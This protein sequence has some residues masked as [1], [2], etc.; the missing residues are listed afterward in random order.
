MATI[1][2]NAGDTSTGK[3]LTGDIMQVYGTAENTKV[4][5]DGQLNVFN[6]GSANSTTVSAGGAFT[7]SN[8][9]VATI[10]TVKQDGA[11]TVVLG[12]NATS[13]TVSTG[14]AA[15]VAG[16]ATST[17]LSGG[18][19]YVS[20]GGTATIATVK[21]G[22]TMHVSNGGQAISATV[23][24]GGLTIF[25]GG[26]ATSTTVKSNGEMT[27]AQNATATGTTA[28]NGGTVKV[29]GQVTGTVLSGS[30]DAYLQV[31]DGGQAMTTTVGYHGLMYV[32][33][34]GQATGTTVN[35]N[36]SMHVS[37]GGQ[38][39]G[40]TV[41]HNGFL[42]VSNGGSVNDTVVSG[43]LYVS[44]GGS[45][46]GVDVKTGGCLY[47][48]TGGKATGKL[49]F[50]DG[51]TVEAQAGAI[52]DFDISGLSPENAVLVNN[53]SL[54][55][56]SPSF[57]LTVDDSQA[58]GNYK[59]AA[60]LASFDKTITVVNTSGT[61]L[62][63]ITVA[64]GKKT[65]DGRDYT[66]TLTDGSLSVTLGAAALI[67]DL[68]GDLTSE[69]HLTAGKYASS[70]NVKNGGDLLIKNGGIATQTTV[71]ANGG[72]NVSS[73]G[74]ADKTTVN[75]NGYMT[76]SSGGVATN[77]TLNNGGWLLVSPG[78]MAGD[79]I[80][81][82]GCTA[83]IYDSGMANAVT[84]NKDGRLGILSGGRAN[85]VT[86][87]EDGILEIREGGTANGVTVETGSWLIVSSGGKV[88]GK[89]TFETGVK[90]NYVAAG[91]ILDFDLTQTTPGA[92]VLVKNISPILSRP[93][94]YT[95]TVDG[96]EAA[97][98]YKLADGATSF[99]ETITVKNISGTELGTITL[100]GG[101]KMLG[102]KGY[103][104]T[105]T[106]GLLSVT[107]GTAADDT[108]PPTITNIT[109]S[110]TEPA[111]SV[112]VTATFDD[113]VGVATKQYKIGKGDWQDYT[114][115]GVTVT[116]NKT[117]YFRATDAVGNVATESVTVT[118]IVGGEP[119]LTGDLAATVTLT[120]DMV[121]SDVNILN[122]GRLY[123]EEDG[124]TDKTTVNSGGKLIISSGGTA[125]QVKEN[126]GY[127]NANPYA[128]VTYVSNSFT[129]LV[130]DNYGTATVHSGTTATDTVINGGGELRVYDGLANN[131]VVR[132]SDDDPGVLMMDTGGTLNGVTVESGG[133]LLL[134]GGKLTGKITLENGAYFGVADF[135]FGQ[136]LDFD[137]TQTA[138]GADALVNNLFFHKSTSY[139]SYTLTIDG[140]ESAGSYK[141]A[142]NAVD[143]D[144]TITVMSDDFEIGTL[145]VGGGKTTIDGRDYT[146]TLTDGILIVTL[147]ERPVNLTGDLTDMF[148]LTTGKY[149]SSV[150]ILDGGMLYV[151]TGGLADKT[152]VNANGNFCVFGGRATDTTVNE[153]GCM[154]VYDD[155]K[156]TDTTVN[157]DGYMYVSHGGQ[158][159]DT[160]VNEGGYLYV[161][162][163]G[164]T[165]K[166]TVNEGGYLTVS[167][168]GFADVVTVN[169]GGYLT[170]SKGGSADNVTVNAAG[171]FYVYSG[172]TA[173]EIH[174]TPCEG[175][176]CVFDG[177]YATFA[178]SYTGV[179]YG[180]DGKLLSNTAVMDGKS[181]DYTRRMLVMNNGT[182]TNTNVTNYGTLDVRSGGTAID[183]TVVKGFV[184]VSSG[185]IAISTTVGDNCLL[186]ISSG[187]VASDVTVNAGG[188]LNVSAGGKVTGKMTFET[189]AVVSAY[190]KGAILD[191]DLTQT[192]PGADPLVN[193]LSFVMDK[194][195]TYTLTL[196]TSQKL[197]TYKLA[198]GADGFDKTIT[199][200]V[201]DFNLG[202][203]T[204]A[205]GRKTLYAMDY[206]LTLSDGVLS[207]T[208]DDVATDTMKPTV[209]NVAADITGPTKDNVTVTAD[210]NDDV[211]VK[212]KLYK[213]NDG[214]WTS[215]VDGVTMTENGTVSFKAVDTSDNESDEESITITN[216][217]KV[218]PTI[219]EVKANTTEPTDSVTVTAT[220]DDNVGLTSQQYK[221]GE[222]DWTDYTT[223][224]TVTTN[225]TV[226]FKAVDTAGNE[227][228][229]QYVVTNI[230]TVEIDETKPVVSNVA[231]DITGPTK[232]NVTVTAD[233]TDNVAVKSKL[234]K[235]NDGAWTSYV[236]SVTMT[237]NGTVSFKAVDTSD[238]ESDEESITITNIDKV[239][240]TISDIAPST[241]E[242]TTSVTVTATFDD[243]VGVATKQYKI[244]E[245]SWTD[246]V[247][248]VTVTE[249]VTVSF[250]ATDTAG[251]ES[252]DSYDVTNIINPDHTPPTITITPS[253]TEPGVA[254]V[255]LTA[256]FDDNVG[257]TS[258]LYKLKGD[259][260]WSAYPEGGVTVTENMLVQFKATDEAGNET[261]TGYDVTNIITSSPDTTPPTIT[262][263]P[264]T[265]EPTTSI[266]VSAVFSD[267]VA[268]ATK[269]YRVGDG[270]WKDYTDPVPVTEN[271][272]VGFRATDTSGNA[273]VE[274][275]MV[276][277][278]ENEPEN[279]KL[280]NK[281]TK[282]W[283]DS[284]NIATFSVNEVVAGDSMVYLDKKGSIESEDG[285]YFNSVGRTG[286][287]EDT[288]DYAK[289]ELAY[290]A[291]L[292]F[293]VDSTIGGTFYVYEATQDKK[294]DL[295]ATQRQKITVKAG[296]TSP[297]KLSTIYLEAGEYFV[298]MEAK[299]PAAKKNPEVSAYYN[300]NLTG[301]K[302]YEDAD[303][304]WNDHAYALDANGKEDKTKLNALLVSGASDFGRGAT[305]IELDT[306]K[307]WVGFSDATDYKMLKLEN[308]VN[309]TLNFTASGKAKLAIWKV[310]TGKGG[311]ITLTSKGSVTV[312]ADKT[313]TIKAKFLDAGEYFVSVTSTDAKKGGDAYYSI[314]VDPATVFFDSNDDGRNNVLYDKKAK[315]FYVEDANHH[316][317]TTTIGTETKV[318]LDTDPVA[319]TDWENF[320]GYQDAT[321]YA[322]IKLTSDG[323]LNFHLEATGD[324][325][326]TV[327]KKGQDKK[328]N[329][330]LETIQTAKLAVAS[331][332]SKTEKDIQIS[333]LE[334]G[335]YY[336]SMAA[337][338]TKANDKGSVFYNVT[339]TL[340][341]VVTSALEMP[342]A[343]AAYADSVQDKLFGESANGL[344]AS[345]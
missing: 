274:N 337:K 38:A 230:E 117:V 327:Y 342:M 146:L 306:G 225:T 90:T 321:D 197:G 299:L 276:T 16:N 6:G 24:S 42:F 27:V 304:G 302:Y 118:N 200:M 228:T 315:S 106:D 94:H 209:S 166:T 123:V 20:N 51:A 323:K 248:G 25:A 61:E 163:D 301:T 271:V 40:T 67:P 165:G 136:T 235:I 52:I 259:M 303:D 142:E 282:E 313:G 12:G 198:E 87:A 335:E 55:T 53:L 194:N 41:N 113:N 205:E 161:E 188:E 285:K 147:G 98:S 339:A 83:F 203:I 236:D 58:A 154:Y 222:G 174:W 62:G 77:T 143:F 214:A 297:A 231:A 82:A 255:T 329:D 193:D 268:V 124:L 78:A 120:A 210:F 242:P 196:G 170:V 153:N 74:L 102:G 322:K 184:S 30:E 257:V 275:Y 151:F 344:L 336:V 65:L 326:F 260:F 280:Y 129:G 148:T 261:I 247:D 103:T 243:N 240:P 88:T 291:A 76:V 107:V 17:T 71:N 330:T 190:S 172:G 57:T 91:A 216:I 265:M 179:Y 300:V 199:V 294:G 251:N 213:I 224:V 340:D 292:K 22:G 63:T 15:T 223:G 252:T 254:S 168:G 104:L 119:D 269:Q 121:G 31:S 331:G 72:V 183:T 92:G 341:A 264:S 211:E 290:G 131:T 219:S 56:G 5:T 208:L 245:G 215:Y 108:T 206:T 49:T 60:G 125:T 48:Y 319:D 307:E 139:L 249:N 277:N 43:G 325:T 195:F 317:E 296:K 132:G 13:T 226:Y 69:Y 256:V 37:N 133:E 250:K 34:G 263:T 262:V 126:G 305:T 288:A 234:Y 140:S 332:A 101:T 180:E 338:S 145:T 111:P 185:G 50:A 66:L 221:I 295:V 310:S 99:N 10:T 100:D 128:S 156:A 316:F 116:N 80:V 345:L 241:T 333:D 81:N 3:T 93:F 312:K 218:K 4:K 272:T 279:D 289:I 32:S 26:A 28:T 162:E 217:D 204:V 159:T 109:L 84:V 212:S 314:A 253:T 187:G 238:N 273:T 73:G 287:V 105:L 18:T 293:S 33:N 169:S 134:W 135:D 75:A 23:S 141:L 318:K 201:N 19:L 1:T 286:T 39:T 164:K 202:T 21:T 150:N 177:G 122:G 298:G 220:F 46:N 47:L 189:D 127:V 284:E 36:G 309:L 176:V 281:K 45:V 233:F 311:K 182:A 320:V 258:S 89:V 130:L 9:G 95:L 115:A 192:T 239:K 68:T 112:T 144:K 246:Y 186:I 237:E 2:V 157:E 229:A 11:M 137:L 270:D 70:V 266:T 158:A 138:P 110:T 324:A 155:G 44:N 343:A 64:E 308:A 8:G 86:V 14:G 267:D 167:N 328:G 54:V 35:E 178:N 191:F 152:T 207:V 59:L 160:T 334:A 175:D 29:Q 97:G 244:G 227:E 283:A 85:A 149:G 181:L 96:T 7:V 79:T 278:I 114:D 173:T 171:Y 232:D